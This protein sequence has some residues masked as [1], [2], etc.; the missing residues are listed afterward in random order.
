[1]SNGRAGHPIGGGCS[2]CDRRGFLSAAGG[3]AGLSLLGGGVWAD[4]PAQRRVRQGATIRAA[5]LYPPSTRTS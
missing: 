1:M 3:M 4:P 5:F 2:C